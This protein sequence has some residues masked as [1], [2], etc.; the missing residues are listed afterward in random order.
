MK[1]PTRRHNVCFHITYPRF[2]LKSVFCEQL[3]L[4]KI[5]LNLTMGLI[6]FSLHPK[7]FFGKK[8]DY[9]TD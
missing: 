2:N 6:A 3:F 4:Y 8:K 7:L 1:E 9:Q 5:C